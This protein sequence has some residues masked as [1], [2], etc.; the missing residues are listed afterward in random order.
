MAVDVARPPGAIP[1]DW[2]PGIRLRGS[3]PH[4]QQC[5]DPQ[6]QGDRRRR[7]SL[8]DVAHLCSGDRFGAG[9]QRRRAFRRHEQRHA[10]HP[11]GRRDCC[12]LYSR[13]FRARPCRA[14]ASE[15]RCALQPTVFHSRQQRFIRDLQRR[16]RG[17]R[18]AAAPTG[19]RRPVHAGVARCRAICA[20][21]PGAELRPVPSPRHLADRSSR[22]RRDFRWLCGRVRIFAAQPACMAQGRRR[23]PAHRASRQ[24]RAAVCDFYSDDGRRRRHHPRPLQC[25]LSR[26]LGADGGGGLPAR[27]RLSFARRGVSASHTK[28]CARHERDRD[29]LQSG[30]WLCR[31]RISSPGHERLRAL[32][33]LPSAVALVHRDPV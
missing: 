6:S 29:H 14:A 12:D 26:R 2:G 19:D 25:S 33:G 21:Q 5:R 3:G 7:R 32:L 17:D 20:H 27:H 4:L 8:S 18:D 24:V 11:L 13:E 30:V 10:R 23:Q 28:S 15:D 1:R 16:R 9:D 31:R 22:R